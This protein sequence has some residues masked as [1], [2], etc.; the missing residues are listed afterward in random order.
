MEKNL[1]AIHTPLKS[2][3]FFLAAADK[4]TSRVRDTPQTSGGKKKGRRN[5]ETAEPS[6]RNE[7]E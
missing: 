2:A 3:F 5:K 7:H 4:S 6:R 1:L